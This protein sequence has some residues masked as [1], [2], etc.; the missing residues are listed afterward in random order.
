MKRILLLSFAFLTVIAFSAM[1]QRT[2]S[3]KVTDDTGE[4]LPGVNVVI[5]GT[6]TGVTTDLDGNYRISVEDGAT[7]IFSYVGFETQEINVGARTA[8]DVT[9]GGATELQE[10][11]VV[12]YGEQR[13][14]QITGAVTTLESESLNNVQAGSVVQ[15]LVGKVAGV[16]VINQSGAPGADPTVRFRG[17]GSINS[18]SAPLYVV[19]GVVYNGNLN[20]INQQDIESMSFLKDASANALYGSRGANGVVL[21][22]TKRGKT[23][24]KLEVTIDSKVGFN[25][26]AVPEYDIIEDPGQYYE[27]AYDRLRLTFINDGDD[28]EVAA[29][30]AASTLISGGSFSLG[31]NNYDVPDDQVINPATGRINP[32]ANLLYSDSWQDESFL[33]GLRTEN[34][35]SLKYGGE[36]SQTFMSVGHLSDEGI[37]I[38]SGFERFTTRLSSDFQPAEWLNIGASINYARTDADNPLLGR[39]SGNV[40]N[41]AGWARTTAPIYPVF[42]RDEDGNKI[43]DQNGNAIYDFGT[44]SN[45]EPDTRPAFKANSNPVATNI[46]DIDENVVDNLSGRTSISINFLKD[47]NFTSNASIDL[48]AQNIQELA[49]PIGGDAFSVN[50][51]ITQ[52]ASRATT[53]AQQQL[54]NWNKDFGD[55]SISVLLGH[56]SNDYNFTYTAGQVTET[57]IDG[58]PVLNN[59]VN[60]QFLTGIEKDYRV[61]GY[62]SRL[63]YDYQDKYFI[64]ASIR[65]DGSS[66]FAPENRWGT[67][68]G[69]G[70]AWSIHKEGFMNGISWLNNLRLKAS[71]GQQGN[72]AIF[73]EDNRTRTGDPDNRNY[74]AYLDQFDIINSGGNVIGLPF[75]QLGNEDLVWETST[76]INA[77]FEASLFNNL[78][79]LNVEYF[80]REVNDLLFFRPIAQSEGVGTVPENVGDMQNVGVE[81]DLLVD[82]TNT[83]NVK[84]FYWNVNLN[85]TH[86]RNE[87][88][89]LPEE[90]IDN[91]RFRLEEGRSRYDYFLRQWGGVDETNGNGQWFTDVLDENGNPTGE[92]ELTDDRVNATEYFVGKSALPDFYGGFGTMI[93]YKGFSLNVNFAYQVGGYGYDGTYQTLLGTTSEGDNFHKDV[94]KSWTPENPTASLPRLDTDNVNQAGTS[95]LFL[96]DLSYLA[97][98]DVMISY[99]FDTNS[100]LLSWSGINGLRLYAVGTNLHTWSARQGYDPR[101]SIV[102]SSINE[103]ALARTVSM[104]LTIKL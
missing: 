93:G 6:T 7:L 66:V 62:F 35:V 64:N 43:L 81:G 20:A 45:G 23:N 63:M 52:R 103:F 68:Y 14:E 59:G 9:M 78:I 51:R 46:L 84:D 34:Y 41:I 49:T 29:Q 61:E 86:F 42:S 38:N 82:L 87:I 11:I 8:I 10:V 39:T 76:N 60:I 91:G 18:S 50:G 69:L 22:T 98:Q 1:A 54:L 12:A 104:G 48:V 47:F 56:E 57:L 25:T 101:M 85:A 75:F 58:L 80:R 72:D 65:R 2:V 3:G 21:I 16:Q 74:Y 88:T 27:A 30:N 24:N 55:H 19:D 13:K 73:Y 53:F 15:G 67:F 100:R 17:I 90:F 79:S 36:K 4:A 26:R 40:S 31:Y 33:T 99:D 102:G 96:I 97:I 94:F 83:I 28:A 71:F 95:D 5:K 70:A 37:M 89:R 92:R 77:G 44:G 32:D